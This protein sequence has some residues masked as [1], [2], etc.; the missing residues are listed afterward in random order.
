[1]GPR[2]VRALPRLQGRRDPRVLPRLQRGALQ[3]LRPRGA[4]RRRARR[5]A[6]P[7]RGETGGSRSSTRACSR[8]SASVSKA[9]EQYLNDDEEFFATYG[10]GLTDAPLDRMVDAFRASGKLIQFL[11]VRPQFNAHRVITADDG[12]VVSRSSRYES[13]GG[14]D[15]RRV[16]HVSPRPAGLDRAGR[17]ARRGDVCEAHPPRRGRSPSRTTASSGLWTRSRTD[18]ASR[19]CTSPAAHR[20]VS[21]GLARDAPSRG[22]ADARASRPPAT[23]RRSVACWRSAATPTTSRSAVA[24]RCSSLA[25]ARP[26]VEV[27]GSSS[28]RTEPGLRG[29]NQRGGLPR[30]RGLVRGRRPRV[31]GRVHAVLRRVG[32]R[33][34]SRT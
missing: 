33:G 19:R 10:D 31:P 24:G 2:G 25:A 29:A 32:E 4:R 7:R 23:E 6:E 12:T 21:V 8:R 16:L 34:S 28:A 27:T 13:A 11:S 9:V 17:R 1:M 30:R 26:D 20:G 5:V 3:R 18:S 22:S 14:A 15:Q